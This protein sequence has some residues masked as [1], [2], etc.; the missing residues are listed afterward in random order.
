MTLFSF[1]NKV[2]PIMMLLLAVTF[3][4]FSGTKRA[5]STANFSISEPHSST[6]PSKQAD[7]ETPQNAEE[8]EN[9]DKIEDADDPFLVEYQSTTD[10]DHQV[11][12]IYE[13][14]IALYHEH[15]RVIFSPPPE[16]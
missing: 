16:V 10:I 8:Q 6:R 14:Q 9:D 4:A 2:F 7:A 13:F 5:I 11:N 15:H 1:N 3:N 12:H